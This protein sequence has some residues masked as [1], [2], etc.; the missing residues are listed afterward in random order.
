MTARVYV[1]GL[2][3]HYT[4]LSK[5]GR[6]SGFSSLKKR[7]DRLFAILGVSL[8]RYFSYAGYLVKVTNYA[9]CCSASSTHKDDTC[10]KL[11]D[12]NLL[13]YPQTRANADNQW[14][15]LE[16][17]RLLEVHAI[18][19]WSNQL[20]KGQC[21]EL[22]FTFSSGDSVRVSSIDT[23]DFATGQFVQLLSARILIFRLTCGPPAGRAHC[24]TC[25]IRISA[26]D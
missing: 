3:R 25:A 6:H 5:K 14:V 7:P 24:A 1:M 4:F 21:R 15:K 18:H 23:F 26:L 19:L 2:V 16:F 13:T 9:S 10:E 17:R 20:T 12:D 22:V 8:C 11:T